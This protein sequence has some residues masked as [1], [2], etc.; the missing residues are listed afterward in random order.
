ML[1]EKLRTCMS[2]KPYHQGLALE[3]SSDSDADSDSQEGSESELEDQ[4]D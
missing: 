4:D 2:H 3:W 1:S